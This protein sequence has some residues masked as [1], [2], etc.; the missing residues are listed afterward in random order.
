MHGK[1]RLG[2][3]PRQRVRERPH[4]RVVRARNGD[5]QKSDHDDD[6]NPCHNFEARIAPQGSKRAHASFR[7]T[8]REREAIDGRQRQHCCKQQQLGEKKPPVIRSH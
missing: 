1:R 2:R 7:E 3:W 8:W 4:G 6:A 5:A